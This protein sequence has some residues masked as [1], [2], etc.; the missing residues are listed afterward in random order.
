MVNATLTAPNIPVTGATGVLAANTQTVQD[1]PAF[2][3]D[4]IVHQLLIA[5]GGTGSWPTE[6]EVYVEILRMNQSGI[7]GYDWSGYLNSDRVQPSTEIPVKANEHWRVIAQ[8]GSVIP[9]GITVSVIG[10]FDVGGKASGPSLIHQESAGAG[11]G[12][13]RTIALPQPAAGANYAQITVPAGVIW[14][15]RAYRGPVTAFTAAAKG[16]LAIVTGASDSLCEM[17]PF[18]AIAA[19][20][21]TC[22]QNDG[23]DTSVAA[24]QNFMEGN[25]HP[26]VLVAGQV[27]QFALF[28]IVA[29]DQFGAGTY[30]VEEW[31]AAAG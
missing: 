10:D 2:Q 6:G 16:P 27:I 23:T 29:G 20:G 18:T 24:G 11:I 17:P 21:E 28:Q 25:L 22:A 3:S 19:A 14:R 8:A 31:A 13:K 15:S 30:T 7:V 12:T 26:V 9:A 4:G 5:P 1:L